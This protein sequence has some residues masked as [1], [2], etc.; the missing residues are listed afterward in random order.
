MN[1]LGCACIPL[2][3]RTM[4]STVTPWGLAKHL[5]L[6]SRSSRLAAKLCKHSSQHKFESWDRLCTQR[7][8]FT[9]HLYTTRTVIWCWF[10][11]DRRIIM[12]MIW[13]WFSS[14][15]SGPWNTECFCISV[16]LTL[17]KFLFFFSFLF[18]KTHPQEKHAHLCESMG[19]ANP[20]LSSISPQQ[21]F[22]GV[23]VI[24]DKIE[25]SFCLYY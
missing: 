12:C 23:G 19:S 8:L 2:P 15:D 9:C 4:F 1:L 22:I 25:T 7:Q 11:S 16:V 20:N 14:I 5:C 10:V 24:Y 3:R 17:R 6:T 13:F 18:G 21:L